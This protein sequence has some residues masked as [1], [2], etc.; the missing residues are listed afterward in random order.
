MKKKLFAMLFTLLLC[1]SLVLP[2]FAEESL[3]RLVDD[4][5]LLSASEEADVLKKLDKIKATYG[6][7]AV[8][9]TVD[10]TEGLPPMAFAD[11]FYD[12]GGYG[13]DGVLL[14]VSMED[15]DWWI[16]TSGY[17]ITAFTD[18]GLEYLSEQFLDDLSDGEYA[19]AFHTFADQCRDFIDQARTGK[20]YNSGNL[21]KKPFGVVKHLLI[22]LAGG[23]IV[24][25]IITGSMRSKLKTVRR[26][27]KATSYVVPGSMQVTRSSDMFLYRHVDRTEK[28]EK[29]SGSSTTHTSSSGNTHGGSGGKF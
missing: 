20:P 18:A 8:I 7:D 25:L 13:K 4:A 28:E 14:L 24:A 15:R 26:Q 29:R 17:G 12:Y 5:D 11:D 19:K 23:L 22:A 16:S 2:A 27:P 6:M 3:P 10:S 21:P 9:V 1:V